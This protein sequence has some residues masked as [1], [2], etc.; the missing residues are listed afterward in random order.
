MDV[1]RG[2]GIQL[3]NISPEMIVEKELLLNTNFSLVCA[4]PAAV[5]ETLGGSPCSFFRTVQLFKHLVSYQ[6]CATS[7]MKN[8]LVQEGLT[9][10]FENAAC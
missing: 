4:T 10:N 1:L 2:H 3:G 9:Y 5:P 8:C 6:N 7:C